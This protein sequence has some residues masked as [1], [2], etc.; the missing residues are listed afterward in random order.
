MYSWLKPKS[1]KSLMS[2]CLQNPRYL[3][4]ALERECSPVAPL[5]GPL[6]QDEGRERNCLCG[7]LDEAC[8]T[9]HNCVFFSPNGTIISSDL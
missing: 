8:L 7:V 1:C 4:F 6:L 5:R 2:P 9:K 3:N